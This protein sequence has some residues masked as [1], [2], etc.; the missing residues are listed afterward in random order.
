VNAIAPND[1]KRGEP[2]DHPDDAEEHLGRLIDGVRDRLTGL[3][4][5][6][7]GK[8]G[9]DR[10]QQHL[11]Q[12]AARERTEIT[13]GNDR[14]QMLDDAGLLCLGDVGGD[15]FR[16]DGGRI[17]IEPATGLEDFANQQPNGQSNRRYGLEIDQRFQADPANALEIAHRGNAVHDGAENHRR[18]HHL[19]QGDETV[20][21]R[22]QL[23]A[24][25]WIEIPDQHTERDCDQD[26]QIQDLVPRLMTMDDGSDRC[27]CHGALGV[28]RGISI[29]RQTGTAD[30]ENSR[31]YGRFGISRPRCTAGRARPRS[32]HTGTCLSVSKATSS[33]AS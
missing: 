28:G 33:R 30:N 15:G 19:D 14:E 5:Q 21:E 24:E 12:V 13:V 29:M 27:C 18:D 17:D 16:I 4:E 8:A 31:V 3:A 23:L 32:S 26:L 11:Q 6:R 22:L 2:D 20:T 7:D 10:D 9:Q 1:T 25:M